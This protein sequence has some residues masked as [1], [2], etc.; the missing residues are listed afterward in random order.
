MIM[1]LLSLAFLPVLFLVV[2]SLTMVCTWSLAQY[3]DQVRGTRFPLVCNAGSK[4]PSH[5]VFALG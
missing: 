1:A 2:A 3:Y 4:P 5:L